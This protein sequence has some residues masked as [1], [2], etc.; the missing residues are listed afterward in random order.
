MEHLTDSLPSDQLDHPN[1]R[2]RQISPVFRQQYTAKAPRTFAFPGRSR[3]LDLLRFL[4]RCNCYEPGI[5]S[6][7]LDR[8]YLVG[9]LVLEHD[10][11]WRGWDGGMSSDGDAE[12]SNA[13]RSP[14][15]LPAR[16]QPN[17]VPFKISVA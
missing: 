17:L 10:R 6:Q 13:S 5:Q 11:H 16:P 1:P 8:T 7:R 15:T 12:P 4:V 2:M 14:Y 9:H 3:L